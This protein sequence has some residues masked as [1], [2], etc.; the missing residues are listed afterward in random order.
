MYLERKH[1]LVIF[2]FIPSS[3]SLCATIL[4]KIVTA[5]LGVSRLKGFWVHSQPH[6]ANITD[7]YRLLYVKATRKYWRHH[8][9]PAHLGSLHLPRE[10]DTLSHL[11][12]SES[13]QSHRQAEWAL[14]RLILVQDSS[15]RS[16]SLWPSLPSLPLTPSSPCL[17]LQTKSSPQ[18]DG[19]SSCASSCSF[20]CSFW[21]VCGGVACWPPHW[22][23]CLFYLVSWGSDCR[24][25]LYFCFWTRLS[26]L[27][28]ECLYLY[29][30]YEA[31]LSLRFDCSS[32]L[33]LCLSEACP[34]LYSSTCPY[35]CCDIS[36]SSCCRV[37]ILTTICPLCAGGSS[38]SPCSCSSSLDSSPCSSSPSSC[39]SSPCSCSSACCRLACRGTSPILAG[40]G[41]SDA[42][43]TCIDRRIALSATR[44]DGSPS[45]CGRVTGAGPCRPPRI[46]CRDYERRVESYSASL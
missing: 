31:R 40:F 13:Y 10:D 12:R 20:S 37:W 3:C 8:F 34:C 16:L 6:T 17:S 2:C 30:Y 15:Q 22:G 44:P 33:S 42:A 43:A 5:T 18:T 28:D 21:S 9:Q 1:R 45:H 24:S 7:L 41:C 19:F 23:F 4:Y 11:Q 36:L 46:H 25:F 35:S 32:C 14:I 29:R 26:L 38:S 39:S 27:H